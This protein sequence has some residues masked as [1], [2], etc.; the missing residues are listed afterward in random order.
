[1]YRP[2]LLATYAITQ[3]L[4]PASDLD[5]SIF[6]IIN[7]IIHMANVG[8]VMC[9]VSITCRQRWV[10]IG[11]G[12]IFALQPVNSEIVNYIS[13]RSESL[14]TLFLLSSLTLYAVATRIERWR[15]SLYLASVVAFAA[16]LGS[17]SIAI[18]LI[19]VLPLLEWSTKPS[20]CASWLRR[21]MQRN[22]P[23]WIVG[24]GYLIVARNQLENAL[25][26]A[27]VRDVSEQ[28]FTQL[29]AAVFYSKL[30]AMPTEL[31]VEHQFSVATTG[32][33]L[34]ASTAIFACLSFVFVAVRLYSLP[35]KWMFWLAWPVVTSAPVVLVPLHVLVNEHRMY[36]PMVAFGAFLS[37]LFVRLFS[38]DRRAAVITATCLL[39][40]YSL[41]VI[42]RNVVWQN[43]KSLWTDALRKA[44]FMP[45][46]HIFVGDVHKEEGRHESA[47]KE[48]RTAAAVSPQLLSNLD[49]VVIYNNMGATLLAMGRFNEAIEHYQKA[50]SVD[51]TYEKA[52][53]SLA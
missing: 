15:F 4:H 43:S 48:Y 7:I 40:V 34:A 46:P 49:R 12:A 11:A 44:P 50:L 14:C 25:V 5:P 47:L 9:F 19:A 52:L 30:L 16:A 22:W 1:M 17:K 2:V 28:V 21:T 13:S 37:A 42:E 31:N 27:P 33:S 6:R 32:L 8:I 10:G 26:K 45:R 3:Y 53:A 39:I 51:P 35:R 20:S 29:K 23:Y 36:L 38:R 24:S 41:L 18:T